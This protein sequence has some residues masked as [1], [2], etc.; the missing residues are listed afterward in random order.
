MLMAILPLRKDYGSLRHGLTYCK[1]YFISYIFP[2]IFAQKKMIE[3]NL[4][5]VVCWVRV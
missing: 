3:S 4:S 5:E 2:E 1:S